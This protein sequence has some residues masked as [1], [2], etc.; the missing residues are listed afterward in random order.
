MEILIAILVVLFVYTP[1]SKYS[2]YEEY[3]LAM[4]AQP[5]IPALKTFLIYAVPISEILAVILMA[6]NKFRMLGLYFTLGLLV[7][8]TAYISLVQLNYYGRIPCSCGG[9]IKTL[10]WKG[11]LFFNLF[12]ITVTSI[13]IWLQRNIQK[14]EKNPTNLRFNAG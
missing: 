7:T 2:K 11:H 13:A 12:F 9:V 3:V 14:Y 1:A 5:L 10:S 4:K 8:F 6:T